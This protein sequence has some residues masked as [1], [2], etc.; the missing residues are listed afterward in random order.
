MAVSRRAARATLRTTSATRRH[1]AQIYERNLRIRRAL[2]ERVYAYLCEHPCV[3]CGETDAV[4][5][6]F[7]HLRDKLAIVSRL[8]AN[9]VVW[10]RVLA[11]IEKCD[12]VRANCHRRRTAQRAGFYKLKLSTDVG[13]PGLEPGATTG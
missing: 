12:V 6:E 7:D 8:V 2:Q 1:N 13:R 4:V 11:E 9:G 10:E 3:D 5:L